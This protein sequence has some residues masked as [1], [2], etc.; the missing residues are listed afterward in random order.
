MQ[1]LARL[2][3]VLAPVLVFAVPACR[4]GAATRVVEADPAQRAQLLAA[5]SELQG[6]WVMEGPEG[7]AYTEFALTS[8]GSAV[9]ETM[10]PGTPHEMINMYALD[11]NSLVLTH[12]C[13]GGNQ[14]RMR[15]ERLVDGRLEFLPDGVGDLKSP[16]TSSTWAR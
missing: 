2:A 4:S 7:P 1:P 8:S 5:V 14:P 16:E 6:R 10:F 12:Y 3:S 11:G 9:R 13:A 15:A